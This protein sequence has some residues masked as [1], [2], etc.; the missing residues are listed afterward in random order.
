MSISSGPD[1]TVLVT[2]GAGYLGARLV[3][4]L[5]ESGYGVRV[6]DTCWYG[7]DFFDGYRDNPRFNLIVGDLRDIDAVRRSVEGCTDVIHLAC[8]SNDPSYDLD[9]ELGEAINYTAFLPLVHASRDAGVSRFIYASSSSVYGVKEEERVTED[10]PLEP[11]TDYSRFKA[12]CEPQL[13]DLADSDFVVT[14]LRPATL[15]GYSPRQR[16]D[17]TVN[18]LTNHAFTNGVIRVFGGA[19]YRPNLHIEDM[20]DAYLRVLEAPAELVQGQIFNVG[21]KNLTVS[22]IADVVAGRFG[23][24]VDVRIEETN[25]HRS[26]RVSSDRIREQLG[27]V[28][29][30]DVGDAVDDLLAAFRAGLLPDSMDDPKYFN[31]RRMNDVL[32]T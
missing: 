13:L 17:L 1:R 11:L 9:P 24:P 3:P 27:F 21:G 2:G 23:E 28:P 12:M 19:Q 26:Y 18:I 30:R 32:A 29:T 7:S 15:C 8:I 31:I 6:L 5:L 25:D 4:R 14:V 16:L 20:C 10:L 22:E